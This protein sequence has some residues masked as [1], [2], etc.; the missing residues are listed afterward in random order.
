MR[1]EEETG[2]HQARGEEMREQVLTPSHRGSGSEQQKL[3]AESLRKTQVASLSG[4]LQGHQVCE[5]RDQP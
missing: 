2:A 5:D 1:A 3:A 4:A